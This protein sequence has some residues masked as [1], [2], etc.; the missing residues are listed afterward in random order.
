MLNAGQSDPRE[1]EVPPV[2]AIPVSRP[3]D[4]WVLGNHRLICGDATDA[5]SVGR[6]LGGVAPHL[7]VSDPPYGVWKPLRPC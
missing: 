3:G 4:L 7:M 6:V 1:D 5:A 2:P